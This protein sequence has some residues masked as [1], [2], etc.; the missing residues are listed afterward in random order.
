MWYG[1]FRTIAD[2]ANFIIVHPMGTTDNTGVTHWNV[3]WGGSTVDDIGFTEALIDDLI[4]TYNIDN[5]RIYSTGMSNGGY[6][7]YHLACNLSNRIAA[8]A[9]VTGSMNMSWFNSCNPNYQMPVM[10]IHGTADPTVLYTTIPDILD[11]WANFNNCNNTPIVTN[12]PDINIMDGCT[13]EHQIWE[14]GD[15]GA[16]VEHFKII[17]GTHTWPGTLFSSSGT[18]YDISASAEIWRFFSQFDINGL[19]STSTSINDKTIN[20]KRIVKI[21]DILGKG[22]TLKYNTLLFYIY[23][24][25]TVDK[26]IVI[27]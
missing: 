14:N 25:G 3:G 21:T 23:D 11:F 1:D 4:A 12:M 8:V 20:D 15:N 17:G 9:S 5:N 19:I 7:S 6:M 27:E 13:A 2:T 22:T 26:R 16:T 24:D 10:E 18:N